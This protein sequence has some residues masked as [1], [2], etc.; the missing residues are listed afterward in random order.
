M[1]DMIRVVFLRRIERNCF[2]SFGVSA[3]MM[4]AFEGISWRWYLEP[5][6][7]FRRCTSAGFGAFS[8]DNSLIIILDEAALS[9]RR[10]PFKNLCLRIDK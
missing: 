8:C 4:S 5:I 9:K 3:A 2:F 1:P 6:S 7:S 10:L